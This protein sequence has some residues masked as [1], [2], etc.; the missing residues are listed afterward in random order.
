MNPVRFSHPLDQ[1]S[2]HPADSLRRLVETGEPLG[3]TIKGKV[4]LVVHDAASY[5]KLVDRAE[6][7]EVYETIRLGLEDLKAGRVEPL[8]SALDDIRRDLQ[9][10]QRS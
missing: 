10:P 1:F 5:Q 7:A 3:L 2:L 6:K 8:E 4:A 9:L